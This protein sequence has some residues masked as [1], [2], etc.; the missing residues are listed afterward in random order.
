[1]IQHTQD[2]RPVENPGRVWFDATLSIDNIYEVPL[3]QCDKG[4][5]LSWR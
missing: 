1:M 5:V 3:P 4:G 2:R